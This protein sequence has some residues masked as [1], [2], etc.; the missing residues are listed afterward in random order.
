MN[1]ELKTADFEF[2]RDL[3]RARSAIVLE[4]NK[5]YLVEARLELLTKKIS[6][7]SLSELIKSVRIEPNGTLAQQVINAMTTNETSFFRDIHP[8]EL[9][10]KSIIP[11]L[12]QAK[13][14]EKSIKIWCGAASS[15]QEPY[16]IAMLIKEHF[17]KELD[18]WKIN[19]VA[20]DLSTDI[21]RKA[22][23]GLYTQLEVNRGLPATF[24]IKYFQKKGLEWEIKEEVRSL[25][26]FKSMNLIGSWLPMSGIDIV[27]LRNVLIY[28][29]METKSKIINKI[30]KILQPEGCLFLGATETM[31]NLKVPFQRI[32]SE[33]SSYYSLQKGE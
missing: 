12:I 30:S 24:L 9:L 28:F 31:L 17:A 6:I 3:V 26:D 8:F 16:T 13:Q 18:G 10:K 19:I 29:D 22:K 20:T 14:K 1:S 15:G 4:D 5:S 23:S 11:K 21:L 25:I 32:T 7:D 33:S 27:F 2:I